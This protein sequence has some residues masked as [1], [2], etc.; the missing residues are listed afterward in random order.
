MTVES[1]L[2]FTYKMM[3]WGVLDPK[4]RNFGRKWPYRCL[5]SDF[6]ELW[7]NRYF[8]PLRPPES[9][10]EGPFGPYTRFAEN[11]ENRSKN[12]GFSM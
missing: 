7:E 5:Y 11:M 3:F 6:K 1:A 2:I 4:N 12:R 9:R 10:P 8:W